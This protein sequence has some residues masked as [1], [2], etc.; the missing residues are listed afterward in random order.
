[1]FFHSTGKLCLITG[2]CMCMSC[3]LFLPTCQDLLIYITLFVVYMPFGFFCPFCLFHPAGQLGFC[4]IAV[5][6]ML[7]PFALLDSAYQSIHITCAVVCVLFYST[8][9]ISCH[10]NTILDQSTDHAAC[11]H[12]NQKCDSDT[13]SS[14]LSSLTP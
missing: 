6:R 7:M 3:V 4:L 13:Y 8:L 9:R 14:S 5:L 10:S 1:M 2:I 11:H 12:D